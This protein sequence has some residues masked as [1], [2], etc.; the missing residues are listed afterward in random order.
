MKKSYE[1]PD[2]FEVFV[3][4]KYKNVKKATYDFFAREWHVKCGC[5]QEDIYAPNR[6]DLV[7]TRIN[8]TRNF[9]LGGY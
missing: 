9:C 7:R 3:S 8:H 5:C 1:I 6:K 4:K 2:P